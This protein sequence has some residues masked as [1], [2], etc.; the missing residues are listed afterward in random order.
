MVLKTLSFILSIPTFSI[1]IQGLNSCKNF[2][3][4]SCKLFF[5]CCMTI[6]RH[7]SLQS[8]QIKLCKYLS[9]RKVFH[10]NLFCYKFN[11][12]KNLNETGR[13]LSFYHN[14]SYSI[15]IHVSY[16]KNNKRTSQT[17][18]LLDYWTTG[19]LD[20]WTDRVLGTYIIS[21]QAIVY[22]P[23]VRYSCSSII[24]SRFSN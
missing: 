21:L 11:L 1:F 2:K 6:Y 4:Y 17:T 10:T 12:K 22:Q 8:F 5:K 13:Q 3:R 23:Y 24:S 15:F 14:V 19:L 18:G 20:Y 9:L 7:V 16:S